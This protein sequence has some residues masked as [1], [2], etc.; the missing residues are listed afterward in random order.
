M[1]DPME[2][3][4]AGNHYKDMVIQPTEYILANKIGFH[5]IYYRLKHF[6]QRTLW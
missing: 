5:S 6:L 4:V 1:T 2:T 3:Q